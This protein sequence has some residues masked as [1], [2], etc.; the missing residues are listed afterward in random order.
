MNLKTKLTTKEYI[1]IK[2]ELNDSLKYKAS[3]R[4]VLPELFL[5]VI[6]FI[7]SKPL[8]SVLSKHLKFSMEI[9]CIMFYEGI[10]FFQG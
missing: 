6:R 3:N 4:H 5:P 9:L 10:L 8:I 1:I 7:C 2:K